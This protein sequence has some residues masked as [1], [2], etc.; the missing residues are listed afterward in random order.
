MHLGMDTLLAWPTHR[1]M[2]LCKR[3][4]QAG[5]GSSASS[6]Q[7]SLDLRPLE[8][9]EKGEVQNLE[10]CILWWG[11][12]PDA[13]QTGLLM[14]RS[15]DRGSSCPN[16]NTILIKFFFFFFA[17]DKGT[18]PIDRYRGLLGPWGQI[19]THRVGLYEALL[20]H[21]SLFDKYLRGVCAEPGAGLCL[22]A[23]GRRHK[24]GR[25]ILGRGVATPAVE[26]LHT[27]PRWSPLSPRGLD[28]AP[29][30]PQI[31]VSLHVRKMYWDQRALPPQF[32]LTYASVCSMDKDYLNSYYNT[33]CILSFLF[34]WQ[35]NKPCG[36]PVR[37]VN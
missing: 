14:L 31:A 13:G 15:W 6:G 37:C 36:A 20:L 7:E 22:Q 5:V 23:G 1:G 2:D 29:R 24:R 10:E 34:Y 18:T 16:L 12:R 27:L 4:A 28:A 32:L 33:K 3:P 19:D 9:G 8:P 17:I 21:H 30:G 35:R 11:P 25:S 26:R